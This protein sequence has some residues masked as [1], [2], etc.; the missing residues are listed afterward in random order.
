MHE[1]QK[2]VGKGQRLSVRKFKIALSALS[3]IEQQ[4]YYYR[5]YHACQFDWETLPQYHRTF[6]INVIKNNRQPYLTYVLKHTAL[7]ALRYTLQDPGMSIKMFHLLEQKQKDHNISFNHL[8]FSFLCAFN[9]DLKISTLGDYI[10]TT[11]FTPEE[12]LDILGKATIDT[13]QVRD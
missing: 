2:L 7:G 6:L 13:G 1:I 11:S 3:P 10:R 5:A 8:A 9:C 4:H 12:A